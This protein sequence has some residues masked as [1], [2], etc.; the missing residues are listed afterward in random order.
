MPY[1]SKY[2]AKIIQNAKKTNLCFQ[3]C[4]IKIEASKENNGQLPPTIPRSCVPH[5]YEDADSKLKEGVIFAL[6]CSKAKY[7]NS[8]VTEVSEE[9]ESQDIVK[10]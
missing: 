8:Q 5:H 1:T 7:D 3:K 6:G 4:L 2:F 9:A 10:L